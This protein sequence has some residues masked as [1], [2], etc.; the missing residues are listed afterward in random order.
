ME[1]KRIPEDAFQ[2][3]FNLFHLLLSRERTGIPLPPPPPPPPT[4]LQEK[5][6]GRSWTKKMFLSYT[7]LIHESYDRL[8]IG[9]GGAGHHQW[10]SLFLGPLGSQVWES[11][12][13]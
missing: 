12:K 8:G 4:S 13:S 10:D 3:A 6:W 2:N 5:R 1:Q 7:N 9:G 11:G